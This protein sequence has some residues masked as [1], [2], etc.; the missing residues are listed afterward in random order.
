MRLSPLAAA[1]VFGYRA[2][3]LVGCALP[4]TAWAQ[5]SGGGTQL[6]EI[7]VTAQ[8]RDEAV[9]KVPIA[10]TAL[11]AEAL[12]DR[13]VTGI[14]DLRSATPNVHFDQTAQGSTTTVVSVRGIV[15][16]D[17]QL[18]VEQPV[19]MYIDGVYQSTAIGSSVMLGPDISRIEVLRGPQGTLYGRNSIGGAV[20]IITQAPTNDFQARVMGGFG[21]YEQ[22]QLQAMVNVPI[23][24][25]VLSARLNYGYDARGGLTYDVTT[26]RPLGNFKTEL[27]RGQ[28]KY[29]P[30]DRLQIIARGE[31]LVSH[32]G[33]NVLQTTFLTPP[34]FRAP[35]TP[36]T[37]PALAFTAAAL[38]LGLAPTQANY[39]RIWQTFQACGA[40]GRPNFT[41]RCLTLSGNDSRGRYRQVDGSVTINYHLTDDVSLKSITGIADFKQFSGQDYDVS[42]YQVLWS[43]AMPYGKAFTQEVQLNGTLFDN[44]LKFATG[45]FYYEL[46]SNDTAVNQALAVITGANSRN[47]LFAPHH[48]RSIG[49]YAQATFSVTDALRLTGGLRYSK[50]KKDVAVTQLQS[51]PAGVPFACTIPF[52]NAQCR[53]PV[54]DAWSAVDYTVG[55]DYDVRPDV[56][57]YGRLAKGFQ[58]GGIN[59]RSATGVPLLPFDPQTAI[60]YELGVKSEWLDHRLR[61]NLAVFQQDV[62]DAQKGVPQTFLVGGTPVS[63]VQTINA[64]SERIRGAEFEV[65]AVP[66]KN[67]NLQ[68]NVG[69]LDTHYKK[70]LASGPLGPNTLDL[71]DQPFTNVPKWTIGF[72]PSYVVPTDFGQIRFQLDYSWQSRQ[73]LAPL[74]TYPT[75]VP[76]DIYTV[77]KAYGLL[78]GR[79]AFKI[80]DKTEIAVW[81]KNLTDRRYFNSALDLAGS[82]GFT[83][84]KVGDPRT[85]GMQVTRDW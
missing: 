56:L 46:H 80:K 20:N 85:F 37:N 23:I 45:V 83:N 73:A 53:N 22:A 54:K 6:E 47:Y 66:V 72:S 5:A 65:V 64:A 1:H 25:D 9:Q 11:S 51:R 77:Q 16:T 31:Y 39:D 34:S 7:V 61:V 36:N 38:Q 70:F 43:L 48:D 50:E 18:S 3:L 84:A 75:F 67:L 62:K 14:S 79:V 63:V 24:K 8:K 29:E 58:A 12:R 21:N 2:L 40:G 15:S 76:G 78:N 74:L 42:P 41:P 68:A 35:L 10:I 19:A 71:S 30:N 33:G 26:G 28:L 82:T 52:P 81:G 55:F 49:P 44:R 60:N 69:Y 57:F 27:F 17:I 59:E 32:T 4:A 13:S